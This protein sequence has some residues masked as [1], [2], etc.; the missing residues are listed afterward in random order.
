MDKQAIAHG[1]VL[2]KHD[3]EQLKHDKL[4]AKDDK[5]QVKHDKLEV[6]HDKAQAKI[7]KDELKSEGKASGSHHAAAG[8]AAAAGGAAL[9]GGNGG[10]GGHGGDGSNGTITTLLEQAALNKAVPFLAKIPGVGALL[11]FA[12]KSSIL[13]TLLPSL[14][15]LA[16]PLAEVGT[17]AATT[18]A[19][20]AGEGAIVAGGGAAATGGGA[21]A[22]GIG[23]AAI[24][25]T[26]AAVTAAAVGAQQAYE[27][28]TTGRSEAND[29]AQSI[30][31]VK[32]KEDIASGKDTR[33]NLNP[34]KWLG[35]GLDKTMETAAEISTGTFF[36]SASKD[37]NE[38]NAEKSALLA[39]ESSQQTTQAAQAGTLLAAQGAQQS[40]H[41]VVAQDLLA[42]QQSDQ[43][44]QSAKK[45]EQLTAEKDQQ[46]GFFTSLSSFFDSLFK[47]ISDVFAS[48]KD[49][50]ASF[51]AAP[52]KAIAAVKDRVVNTVS[53]AGDAY[54]QSRAKG[55]GVLESAGAAIKG[56]YQGAT[57]TTKSRETALEQEAVASGITDPKEL[58]NFMG[59]MNHESAG[60]TAMKE[61]NYKPGSVWKMRGAT[62]G[63]MGVTKEQ[64]DAA[65]ESGGSG[66]MDEFMYADKYRTGKNKMG[67]TDPG[68]ASKYKGRGFTQLTGKNNYADMTK[69]L[70]AEGMNVDLVAHPELA[71]DP[72]IAAKIAT[73]FW[74]KSGAG[75]AAREGDTVTARQRIN[76]GQI[77]AADVNKK[78]DQ[79]EAKYAN[80]VPSADGKKK[81]EPAVA[82]KGETPATSPASPKDA[83]A[84]PGADVAKVSAVAPGGS[85]TTTAAK[86]TTDTKT[87]P[88]N[89][90]VQ[91]DTK[92][93]E[94]AAS[95]APTPTSSPVPATATATAV[96]MPGATKA[97]GTVAANPY[98]MAQ[99]PTVPAISAK[100]APLPVPQVA[101]AP[102]PP[103]VEVPGL[104]RMAKAQEQQQAQN[105]TT[106]ADSGKGGGI[107]NIKTDFDD[108]MLVLMS[109]DRV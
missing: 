104:E 89:V 1:K 81:E 47:G 39:Q 83:T 105:K 97:Q 14:G 28:V 92:A 70:Q 16:A 57:G 21:A 69:Q 15:K 106:V 79:Y 49:K 54:T 76:G 101:Q 90:V 13:T 25:T 87:I 82:V 100:Q 50:V 102:P 63:K 58:S 45:D 23:G 60:F 80:G 88:P 32:S 35:M 31:L 55:G 107:P 42:M 7:D 84:I 6:K 37:E 5:A 61:G 72:K 24:A 8:I 36:K 11:K 66:A 85:T 78:T 44:A 41:D 33:S 109:Y 62:L 34:L 46:D 43:S 91:V 68:D 53:S 27:A 64:V 93:P 96:T 10:P 75:D 26:L 74:K 77:G 40:A 19:T 56:A 73:K 103:P 18:A 95:S 12:G 3:K 52:G 17:T 71:E 94:A 98:A 59:Q 51:I 48:A 65:Y 2:T 9:F 99:T 38:Q 22:T 30:G 86:T 20:A 108:T 29:I 67:N 4:Q